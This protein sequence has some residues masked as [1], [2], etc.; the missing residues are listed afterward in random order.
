M[1]QAGKA[2]SAVVLLMLGCGLAAEWVREAER[3]WCRESLEGVVA[4]LVGVSR[5]LFAGVR[6]VVGV[7]VGVCLALRRVLVDARALV[8]Y[9]YTFL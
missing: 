7:D 8:R 5:T 4:A 6:G 1:T 2:S 9:W 3:R